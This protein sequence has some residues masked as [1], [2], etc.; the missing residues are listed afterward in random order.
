MTDDNLRDALQGMPQPQPGI[1]YIRDVLAY[2]EPELDRRDNQ[3]CQLTENRDQ[4]RAEAKE[5]HDTYQQHAG[6][7]DEFF[8]DLLDL[9]PGAQ[10]VGMDAYDQ[11]P[12]GIKALLADRDRARAERESYRADLGIAL[13]V[14]ALGDARAEIFGL[15]AM[16][17]DHERGAAEARRADDE[18]YAATVADRDR[19][20]EIAVALE[21]QLAEIKRLAYMGGQ[22]GKIVRR[23]ILGVFENERRA[24]ESGEGR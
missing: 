16:L 22:N 21:Q 4:A 2:V 7:V 20:R 13:S 12:R 1:V 10:D 14:P 5:W 17:A 18:R 23:W 24:I 6:A 19:A 15:R 11:I 3:V 9:M 8:G